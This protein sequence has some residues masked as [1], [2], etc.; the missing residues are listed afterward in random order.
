MKKFSDLSIDAKTPT[1]SG[2]IWVENFKLTS[3]KGSPEKING[4]Y[5]CQYNPLKTIRHLKDTK[6]IHELILSETEHMKADD[7]IKEIFKYGI[8]FESILLY[9]IED[10][11]TTQKSYKELKKDYLTKKY[12]LK[13]F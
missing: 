5:G 1:E 3:L 10:K 8:K 13:D 4:N 12:D 6:G 7:Y 2:S 11:D 9:G